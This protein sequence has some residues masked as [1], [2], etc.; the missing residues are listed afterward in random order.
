M[1]LPI[2]PDTFAGPVGYLASCAGVL[3][4]AG[5]VSVTGALNAPKVTL[6]PLVPESVSSSGYGLPVAATYRV[7][8]LL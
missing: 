6:P 8:P 2:S 5:A 4:P 3:A 1:A 7:P